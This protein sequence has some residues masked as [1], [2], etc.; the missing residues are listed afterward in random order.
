[1]EDD[2]T[3]K[4]IAIAISKSVLYICT[5]V[6][7][8]MWMYSC[9]LDP[10]VI[11]ECRAACKQSDTTME[12]VTPGKCICSDRNYNSLQSEQWVIPRKLK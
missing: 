4:H 3:T 1:M 9:N 5:V 6:I 2:V 7:F 10:T 8:G 12:S 11:E